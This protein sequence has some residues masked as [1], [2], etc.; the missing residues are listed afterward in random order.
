MICEILNIPLKAVPY[1][2]PDSGKEVTYHGLTTAELRPEEF[3]MPNTLRARMIPRWLVNIIAPSLYIRPAFSE[4]CI[5]C[6]R[7]VEACP[8]DALSLSKQDPVPHLK[9]P[10]CIG[11]C[12]CHEM[13]PANAIS[14]RTSPVIRAANAL[15]K[16]IK[17]IIRPGG[18]TEKT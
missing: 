15:R 14:M 13:C 1:L 2:A 12:C 4:A 6:G 16:M 3:K 10:V 8:V 17:R 5:K 18:R 11:C 9:G 7:C